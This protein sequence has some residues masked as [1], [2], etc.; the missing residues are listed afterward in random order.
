MSK[1]T[2]VAIAPGSEGRAVDHS[3]EHSSDSNIVMDAASRGHT[4]IFA[5]ARDKGGLPPQEINEETRIRIN[6]V[7]AP[8][9]QW[10]ALGYVEKDANG[11]WVEAGQTQAPAP[12]TPGQKEAAQSPGE[13]PNDQNNAPG[14]DIE[15]PPLPNN[16]D[17][18]VAGF[19]EAVADMGHDSSEVL[20]E[21]IH[22]PSKLPVALQ[23]IA[24][25]KGVTEEE[26]LGA[27]EEIAT[28]FDDQYREFVTKQGIDPDRLNEWI[29][30][31]PQGKQWSTNAI[32][33]HYLDGSFRGYKELAQRFQMAHGDAQGFRQQSPQMEVR[34]R[35]PERRSAGV[36]VGR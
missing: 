27:V 35:A 23:Q 5:T 7:D 19:S 24:H 34:I 18:V 26:M 10:S 15:R 20:M 36:T 33:Q 4:G 2:N 30:W 17:P 25:E 1:T 21:Y 32:Y 16:L 13:A 31:Q 12:S 6:G 22:D 9:R 11:K 3:F 14:D 28:S 29:Q 8:V